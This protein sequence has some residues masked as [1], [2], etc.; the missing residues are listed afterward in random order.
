MGGG[1]IETKLARFLFHY[2]NTP[3]TTTGQSPS[4]LLMG[5]IVRTH[6]D[7]LIPKVGAGVRYKQAK[8]KEQ[9]DTH[10]RDRVFKVNDSVLVQDMINGKWLPGIVSKQ[11]GPVSF[12][13]ELEDQR[14]WKRHQ[15]HLRHRSG[16]AD[17]QET[18]EEMWERHTSKQ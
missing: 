18:V 8:Q 17:S 7:L 12:I 2:R 11:T 13:V 9:H 6:M 15:D 5:R 10:A 16:P 3:H 4:K 14:T 1:S